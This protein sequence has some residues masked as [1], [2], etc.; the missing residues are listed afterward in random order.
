MASYLT[1]K[2][3]GFRKGVY[4]IATAGVLGFGAS[5][6]CGDNG[7]E[8]DIFPT[9]VEKVIDPTSGMSPL[10]VTAQYRCEDDKGI[11]NYKIVKNGEII[12]DG[13]TSIDSI[14]T[15]MEDGN[16]R[17][18]CTDTGDQTTW[19]P[20]E[21]PEEIK[22]FQPPEQSYSQT[23]GVVDKV[24]V[25]YSAILTNVDEATLEV[26]NRD[27]LIAART[28]TTPTYAETF[29]DIPIDNYFILNAPGLAPDTV[30]AAIENYKPTI[31]FD[32]LA[33]DGEEGTRIVEDLE[34]RVGDINLEHNP[35]PLISA[36][37]LDGRVIPTLEGYLLTRE[38]LRDSI[39][40]YEVELTFGSLEGGIGLDTLRG[41]VLERPDR[42]V[43]L[44]NRDEG[45]GELYVSDLIKTAAG[46][47]T[48]I[49]IKRVT[50]NKNNDIWP[51]W[52]PD[53][54]YLVW[55][56][57]RPTS[58][59][60][61][62]LYRV[63]PDKT[64]GD[65]ETRLTPFIDGF[66]AYDPVWCNNGRIYFNFLDRESSTQ[67][68]AR[69]SSDGT[70]LEKIIEE[71]FDGRISGRPACSPDGSQIA[72]VSFRDGNAEIYVSDPI[73]NNLRNITN[74]P[75]RDLLPFWSSDGN[76]FFRS[77]RAGSAD[78]YRINLDNGV[79]RITDN[80]GIATDPTVSSDGTLLALAYDLSLPNHQIFV[81][82]S[83][84][85]GEWTQL[86]FEKA[87]RYPALIPRQ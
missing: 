64:D 37:S 69:I 67:G 85:T 86:T 8:P 41:N 83:D 30:T 5:Y 84:G 74:N 6:G 20:S 26:K 16:L 18:G 48:L 38:F 50:N 7:V 56:A 33:T 87:S 1:D 35:V 66:S 24:G 75:A 82:K 4:T 40:A 47:D 34:D 72:F 73:G 71:P 55:S 27:N 65:D 60:W 36:T 15:F 10:K 25:N 14:I 49:N 59:G 62:A 13:P 28:I 43:F 32:G 52:S 21:G 31:N 78:I 2:L 19:Y 58:E 46:R 79:V 45:T 53:G 54:K 80:P 61:F 12:R 17:E 70:N 23:V 44:S 81:M 42:I 3:K 68:I 57:N 22:V 77:D 11:K 9:A 51:A 63:D 76:I 29:A 39:G